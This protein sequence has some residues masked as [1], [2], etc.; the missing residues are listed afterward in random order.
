[1]FVC[2]LVYWC[3]HWFL[4]PTRELSANVI[5][6]ALQHRK[7]R[8]MV[9]LGLTWRQDPE[10][11]MVAMILM[12]FLPPWLSFFKQIICCSTRL[13]LSPNTLPTCSHLLF[14]D[15]VG[16]QSPF[17]PDIPVLCHA[18]S[19]LLGDR[20]FFYYAPASEHGSHSWHMRPRRAALQHCQN[21]EGEVS[22]PCLE[23]STGPASAHCHM[24]K[25]HLGRL[26]PW[27]PS[28]S[29]KDPDKLSM[30]LLLRLFTKFPFLK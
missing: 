1:M 29:N 28:A 25:V 6:S 23:A 16:Q 10:P 4:I 7:P 15:R 26:P 20:P 5:V 18:G 3:A 12:G 19:L 11:G 27:W 14:L 8:P 13:I 24:P 17:S 30:D 2:L 21:L 9:E 22:V